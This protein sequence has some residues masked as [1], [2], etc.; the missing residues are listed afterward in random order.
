MWMIT[1]LQSVKERKPKTLK[2]GLQKVTTREV[3]YQF[4]EVFLYENKG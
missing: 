4:V 1:H 2:F 3:V